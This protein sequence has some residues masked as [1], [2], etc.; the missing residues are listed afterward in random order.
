MSSATI[1]IHNT[2]TC[3]FFIFYQLSPLLWTKWDV[4]EAGDL[5]LS[6]CYLHGITKIAKQRDVNYIC[7]H[8]TSS[9]RLK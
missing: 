6:N 8:D 2:I 7:I 5:A 4:V 1:L 3:N 9:L